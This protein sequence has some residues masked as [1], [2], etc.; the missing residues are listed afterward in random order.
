MSTRLAILQAIERLSAEQGYPPSLR[1]LAE[2]IGVS[3]PSIVHWHLRKMLQ[4][5]TVSWK[6]R[7]PR[8][9]RVVK[10]A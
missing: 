6:P 1:E 3:A 10:A 9:L 5:G 8:T 7:Q 2:A 4:E